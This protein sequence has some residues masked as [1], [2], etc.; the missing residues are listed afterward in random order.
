M[1]NFTE[2]LLSREG[3]AP[4]E[5][6]S[7]VATLHQQVDFNDCAESLRL[8]SAGSRLTFLERLARS[9]GEEHADAGTVVNRADRTGEQIRD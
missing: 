6:L 9:F 5:P 3:E 7:R 1:I 2:C 8:T 4:S